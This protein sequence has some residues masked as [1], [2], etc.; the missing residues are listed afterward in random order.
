[1]ILTSLIKDIF[2]SPKQQNAAQV[3]EG[4]SETPGVKRVL[5][6]GGGSKR[7][8]I[9]GYFSGWQHDLLDIDPRG[10]PDIVCDARELEKLPGGLY[11]AVHCSHNLEHYYRHDGLR[12]VRGFHHILNDTGFAEVF[13]P[14]FAQVMDALRDRQ[15]ELDDVL[16]QS[17]AGPITAHDIVYGLQSE[18]QNSG[19]DFYAHKT[20]F[21]PRSLVKILSDG[22]FAK[23]FISTNRPLEVHALAFKTEP[24]EEQYALFRSTW[25][26]QP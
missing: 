19:Q 13:V 17:A 15:L 26:L 24:T 23:V 11:D 16:Y 7:T 22:G 2:F 18:I 5:N 3:P 6:V 21:T 1:M 20:G 12:V 8:P 10:E 14:D 4:V 9:P 25:N